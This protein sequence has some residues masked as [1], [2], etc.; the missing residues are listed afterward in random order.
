MSRNVS[1]LHKKQ[2]QTKLTELL[3]EVAVKSILMDRKKRNT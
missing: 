2:S 3:M 1:S